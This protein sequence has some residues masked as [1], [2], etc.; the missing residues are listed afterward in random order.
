M[1]A[2]ISL[3]DSLFRTSQILSQN[4]CIPRQ[5]RAVG[6]TCPSLQSLME[7]LSNS[8][9]SPWDYDLSIPE[10]YEFLGGTSFYPQVGSVYSHAKRLPRA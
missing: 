9:M 1:G 3:E 5:I 7:L 6:V 4:S 10:G 8:I 2:A